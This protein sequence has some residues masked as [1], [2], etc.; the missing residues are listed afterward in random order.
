MFVSEIAF[1][2]EPASI[3][4][5]LTIPKNTSTANENGLLHSISYVTQSSWLCHQHIKDDVLFGQPWI[6]WRMETILRL[7]HG[8]VGSLARRYVLSRLCAIPVLQH[9]TAPSLIPLHT[10]TFTLPAPFE[11]SFLRASVLPGADH[12]SPAPTFSFPYIHDSFLISI[13][14]RETDGECIRLLRSRAMILAHIF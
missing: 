12:S 4:G 14:D 7:A 10:F 8:G 1:L 9:F 11:V 13:L 2:G 3:S 6:S 5:K